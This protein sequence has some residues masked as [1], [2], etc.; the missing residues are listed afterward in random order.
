MRIILI[1]PSCTSAYG[2]LGVRKM[3]ARQIV[4]E[5]DEIETAF[6][7]HSPGRCPSVRAPGVRATSTNIMPKDIGDEM[8][9]RETRGNL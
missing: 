3:D 4:R 1:V 7:K 2:C 8:E 6:L 5:I 9:A